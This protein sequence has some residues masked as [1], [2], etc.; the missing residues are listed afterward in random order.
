[1]LVGSGG[2]Q[3]VIAVHEKVTERSECLRRE[4]RWNEKNEAKIMLVDE[5]PRLFSAYLHTVYFGAEH[6][7]KQIAPEDDASSTDA[8]IFL[9]K[10]A[11]NA[12]FLT[13][14][15]VLADKLLDPVTADLVI[16]ELI[17]I[18]Y[19]VDDPDDRLSSAVTSHVY[20]STTDG[21]TLRRPVRYLRMYNIG[22]I[23]AL[24]YG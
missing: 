7:K 11:E 24:R 17:R 9:A 6:L 8:D 12:K 20:A 3:Q 23:W 15:Y 21:S 22:F 18:F 5:D 1:V 16:D 10:Q 4:K 13:D 2:A 14:L 19:D